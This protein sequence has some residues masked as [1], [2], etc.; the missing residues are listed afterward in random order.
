MQR[1][2]SPASN[3]ERGVPGMPVKKAMMP[4]KIEKMLP[5]LN[6]YPDI[7]VAGLLEEGFREGFYIPSEV[8]EV[9]PISTNVCS[10]L[11]H[12][13]VVSAKLFKEVALGRIGRPVS[14]PA[15]TGA[16][17]FPIGCGS[18]EGTGLG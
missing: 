15:I 5:F 3:R 2:P 13:E 18:K 11:L 14:Y 17:G 7:A 8:Q 9:P 10:A 6:R 16:S 1:Q 12:Q 4:V